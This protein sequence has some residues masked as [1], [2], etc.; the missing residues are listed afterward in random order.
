MNA[1]KNSFTALAFVF[2]IGAA[3]AFKP[4]TASLGQIPIQVVTTNC[5]DGFVEEACNQTTG[6]L[7]F[8]GLSKVVPDGGD[9]TELPLRKQP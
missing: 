7:C 6:N 4:A 9:C 1:L 5:P 8:V 3:F 2:A